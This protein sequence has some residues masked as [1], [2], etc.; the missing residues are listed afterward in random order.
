MRI[1]RTGVRQ[2][3]ATTLY[4]LGWVSGKNAALF[5]RK[6]I[7]Q[8]RVIDALETQELDGVKISIVVEG[9]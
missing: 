8:C 5:T 2:S 9:L 4:R 3:L 1:C 7:T 6:S